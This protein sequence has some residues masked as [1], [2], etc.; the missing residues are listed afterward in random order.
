MSFTD[1]GQGFKLAEKAAE[2]WGRMVSAAAAKGIYFTINSAYRDPEKQ[3]QLFQGYV[4]KLAAWEKSGRKTPK[5]SPVAAP[6]KSEHEKGTA[7]D[8]AVEGRPII[9]QWLT[10]N[11]TKYGFY[12]TASGERWHW[13]FYSPAPPANLLKRHNDN[14]ASWK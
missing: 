14:L 7:V 13:A 11:A 5:P 4:K 3:K 12:A 8:I 10:T 6:G 1:V 2:A 9:F